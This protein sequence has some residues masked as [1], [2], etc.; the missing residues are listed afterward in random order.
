[1]GDTP[2]DLPIEITVSIHA[3]MRAVERFPEYKAA[4][5]VD[6]VREAIR[7]GR[8]TSVRPEEVRVSYE[9]QSLYVWTENRERIFVLKV[10]DDERSLHVITC[11]NGAT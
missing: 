11:L 1:M 8:L 9:Y 5:I 2:R 3:R 7:A 6:D 10:H 4:R